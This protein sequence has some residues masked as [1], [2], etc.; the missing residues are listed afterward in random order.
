LL[1]H[2]LSSFALLSLLVLLGPAQ[3]G[4]ALRQATPEQRQAFSRPSAVPSPRENP[5]TPEKVAL[6]RALFFDPRLSGAGQLSCASCHNPSLSWQDGLPTG[7]GHMGARL[8]RRTPSILDVAW[9][10]PLFWDGRAA[11]LEEQAKGPLTAEA[12]MN[13]P[14]A[15]LQERVRSVPDYVRGFTAAFPGQP[16]DLDTIAKAIAAFER[17][18]ASRPAPFDRWI[19][20]DPRAISP[21]AQRGF[22]LFTGKAACAECHSGWRFTDDGFRDIGLPSTDLGRGKIVPGL[23]ILEHAFKTPSLRNVAERAPYMHDGSLTTL[24]AVVDHYDDGFVRRPSLATQMRPLGLTPEERADLVAFMRTLS[25]G[26]R[27]VV[28]TSLPSR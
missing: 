1:R 15:R 3:A 12:E 17:T 26:D 19:E 2:L 27:P 24:E 18:V 20:G 4:D 25:G 13:M 7:R 11:T 21:A 16:I 22:A 28:L 9:A 10:E 6:G 5:T 14:P 23:P 8:A